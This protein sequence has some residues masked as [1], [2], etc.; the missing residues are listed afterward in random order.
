MPATRPYVISI[1]GFDPSGGAGLLADI[2]TFEQHG[3]YGLAVNTANTIQTGHAF[4]AVNWASLDEVLSTIDALMDA[5]P[6]QYVK[7]GIV[8]SFGFLSAVVT[9]LK[10]K[11]TSIRIITDP[12]IRSSS[13]FSFHDQQ[14]NNDITNLLKH[15]YLLTPNV[16]EA[17]SLSGSHDAKV[18]ALALSAHC[19]VLLKGGH[20][21]AEPGTDHLYTQ[22]SCITLKPGRQD[23]T[24]K[25]GS[26]CVLSA[27][28]TANLALGNDLPTA[29]AKAKAY[30]EQFL[31][32]HPSLLGY[33]HV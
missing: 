21:T 22:G 3:V 5:Y 4:H 1:A 20:S 17:E 19:H 30:V 10:Q 6:V 23:I 18:A 16:Q 15:I 14:A 32:S 31:S 25:H 13:G 24:A 7:T 28:I 26:G 29:C 12:V 8:P 11:N 33:H 9:H 2:K 27:A